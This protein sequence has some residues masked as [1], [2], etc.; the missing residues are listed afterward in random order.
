MSTPKM[1]ASIVIIPGSPSIGTRAYG[2]LMIIGS[3]FASVL[4]LS[5]MLFFP[6]IHA[7]MPPSATIPDE[8]KIISY[9]AVRRHSRRH[10][11]HVS[12]VVRDK[13]HAHSRLGKFTLSG[14]SSYPP[15]PVDSTN[16]FLLPSRS[17]SCSKSPRPSPMGV[18]PLSRVPML[19]GSLGQQSVKFDDS[20]SASSAKKPPRSLIAR[21]KSVDPFAVAAISTLEPK[22]V[23]NEAMDSARFT[24][25]F[26]P[27]ILEDPPPRPA[28]FTP[29]GPFC[30]SPEL[31]FGAMLTREIVLDDV[32]DGPQRRHAESIE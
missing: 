29:G 17:R 18:P 10:T 20:Y 28:S 32:L 25:Q 23:I 24:F 14:D 5:I 16:A 3:T 8:D 30:E 12:K 15:S 9:N 19:S 22:N 31:G 7:E 1:S 2:L 27:I 11:H 26:K 4:S 13:V 6:F 21:T